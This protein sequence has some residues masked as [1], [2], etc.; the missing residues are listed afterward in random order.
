MP[1]DVSEFLRII[2]VGYSEGVETHEDYARWIAETAAILYRRYT[3][4]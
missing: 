2:A 4:A 1:I 3:T